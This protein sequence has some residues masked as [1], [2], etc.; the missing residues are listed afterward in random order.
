MVNARIA[1]VHVP[2]LERESSAVYVARRDASTLFVAGPGFTDDDSSRFQPV[3]LD[4]M[5]E[6]DPSLAELADL[7]VGCCASRSD[8]SD[9]WSFGTIPVGSTFLIIYEVRPDGSNPMRDEVGGAFANCWVVTDS[10]ESALR[11]T[12]DDLSASGWVV[13][14]RTSEETAVH[15]DYGHD[16]HFRQVQIDGFVTVFHTF[17]KHDL[18]LS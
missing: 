6:V 14:E 7:E 11:T 16:P 3:P 13:I 12:A 2:L 1:L 10:L 8:R 9:R 18:E 15:D 17:P 5:L 4:Q